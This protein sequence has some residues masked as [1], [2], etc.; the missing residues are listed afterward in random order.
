MQLFGYPAASVFN[1]LSVSVT[2]Y[3]IL[4]LGV[5]LLDQIAHVGVSPTVNLKLICREIIFDVFQPVITVGLPERHGRTDKRP[6]DILWLCD[7]S[8]L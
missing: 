5:L 4:I 1:K 7:I 2:P 3:S 6:D 8:A